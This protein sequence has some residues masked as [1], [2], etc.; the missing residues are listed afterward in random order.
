MISPGEADEESE[1]REPKIVSYSQ[2]RELRAILDNSEARKILFDPSRTFV[3]AVAI[4]KRDE[5][6][7]SWKAEIV[8]AVNA[9][10]SLGVLEL[11]RATQDDIGLLIQLRDLANELIV[12]VDKLTKQ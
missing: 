9:L 1:P 6:A 7:N 4:S 12:D 10:K 8:E 2:V 3:E 11:K 5:M